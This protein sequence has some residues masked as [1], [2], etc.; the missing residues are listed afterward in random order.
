[1]SITEQDHQYLQLLSIFHYVVGGITALFGCFPIFHLAIGLSML[2]G[3]FMTADIEGV[4]F[5]TLFGLMFTLIPLLIILSFWG[6]AAA[7]AVSGYFIQTRQRRIFSIVMAAI[8]CAMF[9]FGTVL[10]VFTI[11]VL[12]RP[13]VIS[14]YEQSA[15][16]AEEVE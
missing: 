10:G 5:S 7:T 9:P 4:L 14:L 13:S 3:G 15:V 16:I 1:M 12:V 6:L 8:N 2:F 11:I